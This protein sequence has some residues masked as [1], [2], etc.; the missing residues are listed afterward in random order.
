MLVRVLLLAVAWVALTGSVA[1]A[2][3]VFAVAVGFAVSPILP[4]GGGNAWRLRRIVGWIWLGPYFAWQ[5]VLAN[6]RM[7]AVVLGSHTRVQAAIVAVPLDATLDVEIAVLANLI[8]LTPGTLSVDVSA[9]RRV[10]YVHTL[11]FPGE[12]D[13]VRREIKQG[14]ERRVLEALR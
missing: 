13:A 10:L 7:A 9:D 4:A 14:F 5:L 8:T 6:I 12:A 11:S 1:P 3:I 2:N